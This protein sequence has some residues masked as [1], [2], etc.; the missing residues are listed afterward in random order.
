MSLGFLKENTSLNVVIK[1]I[2]EPASIIRRGYIYLCIYIYIYA[3]SVGEIFK[4]E[5]DVREE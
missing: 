5:R 2:I 4:R 1:F 3:S